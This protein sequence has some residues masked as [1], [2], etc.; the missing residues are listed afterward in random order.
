MENEKASTDPRTSPAIRLGGL[1]VPCLTVFISSFCI[2]VLEL[3][4]GRILARYLGSSL[5]TWTSVIGVVLAG[6]TLGNYIG[7]RLADRFRPGKTLA[8]LFGIA[9]VCC[10]L[11]IVTNNL[12]GK[13][14]WLW[15]FSW[16]V[17]TLL[18]VSLVFLLP[19]T[20]LGTI[21]P[22]VAKMALERG[23]PIGRTVG[24][25]YAWGAVGSIAGTFAAGYYLIALMGT[26]S[27]IWAVGI[28]MIIMALLYG[29]K[30]WLLRGTAA[31]F[32]LALCMGAAPW[33][34]ADQAGKTLCLKAEAV[35]GVIYEDE[36]QY[37]YVAVHSAGGN[38]EK[39][40]FMQDVLTHSSMIV[41]DIS[42]L[43]YSYEQ[44]MAAVTHRFARNKDKP[45]FL[46]IGGGGYVLPRYLKVKWPNSNVDV[47]EIDPGVTK[48]AIKAF[49]FDPNMGIDT[50]Q[51]DARNY[52]EELMAAERSGQP[53][54]KYDFIYE[55][56]LDHY[57]VP[58]QL[59]TREFNDKI[60]RSLT[61]SGIYMIELIDTFQS[62]QFLGAMVN[63]LQSS[64]PFVSVISEHNVLP[65]DRNTYVV[66][67][68]KHT[69]DLANVCEEYGMGKQIWYFDDSDIAQVKAKAHNMVLT[70]N[71]APVENLLAPVIRRD[72]DE[73][74][75][76]RDQR[77]ARAIAKKAEDAAWAGDLP[78]TM[79]LLDK[80]VK[81]Q[82]SISVRA[83]SVMASIFAD[84]KRPDDA[85]KIYIRALERCNKEKFKDQIADLQYD[86]ATLL[87]KLNRMKEAHEQLDLAAQTYEDI[88]A[89]GSES[90]HVHLRLGEIAVI[91]DDYSQAAVHFQKAVDLKPEDFENNMKLVQALEQQGQFDSAIQ[92]AQKAVEAMSKAKQK[93]DA[94][95]MLQY[96]QFLEFKK[97]QKQKQ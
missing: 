14:M 96:R 83:Y 3:V 48:A 92:A 50:I 97:A 19:S 44:I 64:F 37:C 20:L 29:A 53:S 58:F 81:L 32:V 31:L 40:S 95:K 47:A 36:T 11:T 30:M 49:G 91:K 26:I 18:H 16:P 90:A 68:A 62:A 27:I 69:L 85:I 70:D 33:G 60:A 2:M 9:A 35:P 93:E 71:Y 75:E 54:E 10:V 73:A 21:S 15:G 88:L 84:N 72:T 5:Y 39:R 59:T 78:K 63:T 43:E 1:I 87:A 13:W 51:L 38:P 17:R 66:L 61:D 24:D 45:S 8:V 42:T 22:V 82:E 56:A 55:D 67:A 80:L 28:V 74:I 94:V 65:E 41:G 12:V 23:L 79:Q 34:W 89:S 25:I 46:I 86:Y 57:G 52:L 7:G 6:I 4:A 76:R 77:I